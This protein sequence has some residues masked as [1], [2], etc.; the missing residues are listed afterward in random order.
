MAEQD[1]KLREIW[2]Q[3]Q[4]PVIFRAGAGRPLIVR[5]PFSPSNSSWLRGENTRKPKWN[6]QLISWEVP[7]AWFDD[8][9]H[10]LLKTYGQ[11]Y[12]IQLHREQQKCAPACWNAEGLH[13]ECS[14]LGANHGSGHPGGDWHEIAETFACQWGPLQYACRLI[15]AKNKAS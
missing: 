8:L 11:T 13:C 12:V 7:V 14:C 10:R 15:V 9:I 3:R 2:S 1:P 5:L 4:V 6:S